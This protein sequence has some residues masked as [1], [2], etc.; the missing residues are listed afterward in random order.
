MVLAAVIVLTAPGPAQE[1]VACIGNLR[2][3]MLAMPAIMFGLLLIGAPGNLIYA[4]GCGTAIALDMSVKH[5]TYFYLAPFA[6]ILAL[7]LLWKGRF[8]SL[9]K[10]GI[11]TL[12][13]AIAFNG[14]WMWQNSERLG[15]PLIA[16]SDSMTNLNGPMGPS[17]VLAAVVRNMSIYMRT[18]S[19]AV[20]DDLN[21]IVGLTSDS[22]GL[23][24]D[25]RAASYQGRRFDFQDCATMGDGSA[26]GNCYTAFLLLAALTGFA[27]QFKICSPL[28][29]Y[30]AAIG[31]SFVLFSVWIRWDPWHSRLEFDYFLLAAPFIAIVI[32]TWF[33]RWIIAAISGFLLLNATL[34]VTCEAGL[35]A[36][37]ATLHRQPR[38]TL[39]FAGQPDL[40]AP[41][42]QLADDIMRAG[43]TK[44][45]LKIG[46]DTW[47][48]P[49]WVL[50]KDRGFHGSIQHVLTLDNLPSSKGTVLVTTIYNGMDAHGHLVPTPIPRSFP[51][52][53]K[54]TA[55][56]ACY[57]PG[58]HL[59]KSN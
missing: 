22:L 31:V 19:K 52:V 28:G 37:A 32:G 55:W 11:V 17:R 7:L 40:R 5:S 39:Y 4:A 49:L 20:T 35:P 14:R 59:T 1:S 44:V 56:N 25:D 21:T 23:H 27:W 12:A 30:L 8:P 47:E 53:V 18:P 43:C 41:T 50:L 42:V 46:P 38:E 10:L 57:P 16:K 51:I 15:N 58:V 48:Y 26:L 3:G 24:L 9:L 45:L 29:V 2:A 54:Y 13:L 6:A 33:N 36:I 34:S